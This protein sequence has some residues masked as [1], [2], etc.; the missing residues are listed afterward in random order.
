MAS[1]PIAM[2]VVYRL[3]RLIVAFFCPDMACLVTAIYD[4]IL[5]IGIYM[6]CLSNNHV[7]ARMKAYIH[8]AIICLVWHK[9]FDDA[10]IRM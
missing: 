6:L 4:E 9:L 3:L 7:C 8:D 2:I 10:M 5:Y 1:S